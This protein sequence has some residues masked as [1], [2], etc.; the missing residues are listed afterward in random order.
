[1][2]RRNLKWI[3]I[4]LF[5]GGERPWKVLNFKMHLHARK[6]GIDFKEKSIHKQ[7]ILDG[8]RERRATEIM[9]RFI[10][11]DDVILDLGANIKKGTAKLYIGKA[12]N[13]HSLINSSQGRDAAYVEVDSDTV[14][15]FLNGKKPVTFLRMDIEGYETEVIE[16]MHE[17]LDSPY[18]KRMFV[19]I[20]PHRVTTEKMQTLLMKLKGYG[21]ETAYCVSRDKFQRSVLDQSRVEQIP[22]AQL[23]DDDRLVK[24]RIGFELFLERK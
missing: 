1:M 16:G 3:G 9:Q 19:E 24:D 2:L 8:V 21:F 12:C 6:A 13:L 14:D 4:L 20:H 5:K 17:T 23:A 7:L 15:N 22:L 11:S 18:I 10:Q